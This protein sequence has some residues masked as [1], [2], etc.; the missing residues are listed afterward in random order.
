MTYDLTGHATVW[1]AIATFIL[2]LITVWSVIQQGISTK[3]GFEFERVR[4]VPTVAPLLSVRIGRG[5]NTPANVPGAWYLRVQ[6]SGLGPACNPRLSSL[7]NGATLTAAGNTFPAIGAGESFGTLI[8]IQN[9]G[10]RGFHFD[11]LVIRYE[12]VFGNGYRTDYRMFSSSCADHTWRRPWV[13][14]SYGI[15]K[16][17]FDSADPPPWG[18]QGREYLDAQNQRF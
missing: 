17:E 2:A 4:Q 10:P 14:V 18:Q 12:D 6:N 3:R 15:A 11:E 5:E 8:E 13:G 9:D 1:L 7:Y 16:P